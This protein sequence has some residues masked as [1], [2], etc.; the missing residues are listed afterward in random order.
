VLTTTLTLFQY[1]N[2]WHHR[3]QERA[4]AGA[5]LEARGDRKLAKCIATTPA[6]RGGWLCPRGGIDERQKPLQ[7]FGWFDVERAG[8]VNELDDAQAAFTL[9]VFGDER[10]G[11]LKSISNIVLGKA[12]GLPQIA[13]QRLERAISRRA[14]R[15][16][17]FRMNR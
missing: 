3:R 1:D 13:Q 5:S 7:C 2:L 11:A 14:Q 8:D 12:F 6:I 15:F 4:T 16:A 10:L 17:H 9:L